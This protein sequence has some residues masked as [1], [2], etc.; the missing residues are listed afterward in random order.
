M[1]MIN[2]YLGVIVLLAVGVIVTYYQFKLTEY[3]PDR[4][5]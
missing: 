4:D 3:D 1:I 5:F 2:E